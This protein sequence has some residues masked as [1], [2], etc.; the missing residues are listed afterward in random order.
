MKLHSSILLLATALNLSAPYVWAQPPPLA[1][2]V[3]VNAVG[4][5]DKIEIIANGK[6]LTSIGI[7]AGIASS[8]LGL[9]VGNYQLQVIALGCETATTP[10]QL[11]VGTTPILIAYLERVTD[12]KTNITK[13]FIRLL[14]LKAEPET[15][16]YVINALSVDPVGGSM[17]VTAGGQTQTV[18]FRKP[19]R[20]EGKKLKVADLAG[21]TDETS[22]DERGSYYCVLF[23]KA[24]GKVAAI[25]VPE[26]IYRW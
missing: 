13:S 6:R 11:S 26:R 23:H 24:D 12:P 25:L 22:A 8:G 1:G 18:E 10:L 19:A 20:F 7:A 21:S 14:Q 5:K 2:F 4:V 16:K 15:E 17:S 3:F 9:P